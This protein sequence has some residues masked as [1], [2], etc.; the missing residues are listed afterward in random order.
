M[1]KG[2]GLGLSIV[3]SII[4]G[5]G[6]AI[7]VDSVIDKGTT[8]RVYLPL[9]NQPS[10][11][12]KTREAIAGSHTDLR[13]EMKRLLVIDDEPSVLEIFDQY[14]SHYG[15]L[16]ESFTRP[17]EA[18]AAFQKNPESYA[19]VITDMTMSVMTGLKVAEKVKRIRCAV[20]VIL[21]TGYTL[22]ERPTELG[23][24]ICLKKPLSPEAIKDAICELIPTAR[25][26]FSI[27]EK[28]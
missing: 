7:T 6:G 5:L 26:L 25:K 27:V 9:I 2:T 3:H 23:I 19:L 16:V 17:D 4:K 24:S 13:K 8:F 1:G 18:L 10:N 28:S 20:P 15:F 14:L 12:P 11:E 21:M 22:P